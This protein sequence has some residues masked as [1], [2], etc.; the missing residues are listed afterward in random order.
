MIAN[1]VVG[2]GR[3]PGPALCPA[4]AVAVFKVRARLGGQRQ[5][6]RKRRLGARRGGG[7][8]VAGGLG[9]ARFKNQWLKMKG[10][11]GRRGRG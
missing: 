11:P 3:N 7:L 5:E 4:A 9:S 6:R 10:G 8:S 2:L 1:L